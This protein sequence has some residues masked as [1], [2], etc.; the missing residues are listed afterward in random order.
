LSIDYTYRRA[1]LPFVGV[2]WEISEEHVRR[3]LLREMIK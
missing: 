3:L 1:C 2:L